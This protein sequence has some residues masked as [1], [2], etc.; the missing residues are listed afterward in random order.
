M[1]AMLISWG[2]L[3]GSVACNTSKAGQ[4]AGLSGSET[5]ATPYDLIPGKEP[6]PP[7]FSNSVQAGQSDEMNGDSYDPD[8]F[9]NNGYATRSIQELPIPV[10]AQFFSEKELKEISIGIEIA[11]TALN[12]EDAKGNPIAVFE[13][14][15]TW[16]P[17]A[18]LIYKAT[19]LGKNAS[20]NNISGWTHFIYYKTSGDDYA[21]ILVVDWVMR[22]KEGYVGRWLV[23][24]ELGH[25]MGIIE[26]KR[27]DYL[28]DQLFPL[29]DDSIMTGGLISMTPSMSDYE[30][31]MEAQGEYLVEAL[32]DEGWEF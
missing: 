3:F 8:T 5:Q 14:V 27:I 9:L 20:G 15:D 19:E 12:L 24:H 32:L 22:L 1:M 18:R 28:K 7:A 23:A 6:I 17:K 4:S 10:Y 25:A 2:L 13:L 11:N 31:M 21:G 16:T 26:H 29:E 30:Y